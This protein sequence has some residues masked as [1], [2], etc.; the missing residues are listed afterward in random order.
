M[1]LTDRRIITALRRHGYKLTPQRRAVIGSIASSPDH[2]TPA[3]IY[4]KVH[5]ERPDIGLATI[6]RT[7][8]ILAKLG[9]I[10]FQ[11]ILVYVDQTFLQ[12][13]FT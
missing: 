2:L 10:H 9:L 1:R 5:Q 3:A 6:Y 8:E 7:L 12:L 4:E 11:S 13:F